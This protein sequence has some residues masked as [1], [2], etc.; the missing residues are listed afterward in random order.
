MCYAMLGGREILS[1]FV[2]H[3][4]LLITKT[5]LVAH[6]EHLKIVTYNSNS[7]IATCIFMPL[8]IFSMHI[9]KVMNH[10]RLLNG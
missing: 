6:Q 1:F 5:L 3:L 8:L 4:I 7:L 9:S 10:S 2:L